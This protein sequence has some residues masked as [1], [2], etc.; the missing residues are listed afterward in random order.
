MGR[1]SASLS[2]TAPLTELA[3][4]LRTK[5]ARVGVIGLGYVGLPLAVEFGEAGFSVR[6]FDV[7]APRVTQVNQGRSYIPDVP[8][9]QL[10]ELVRRK[11]LTATR[12]YEELSACDAIIICVPTPLRK[13]REPDI[14]F[15]LGAAQ[16]IAKALRPGHLIVLEST[17]YPGTTEE[18][19]LPMLH[20]RGLRVGKDFS[21][22]F[23]PERIDPGNPRYTTH[24]IP[25]VVGG[26][27]PTCQKLAVTLY[28]QVVEKVVPVSSTKVAEMVKLLENTFRAV[29]IG[30]VNEIAL[31]CDKLGLDVWEVIEAAK[32]KPFGFMAFYPG[33]GIGGHCIPHD[34]MYLAWKARVHGFEARFIE[35]ADQMNRSMP[36]YVVD[37]VARTLNE[38][39]K[40]LNGSRILLLGLA[41]KQDVNDTR[42]SPAFE[43]AQA[44]RE[45]GGQVSYHDP[46]VPEAELSGVSA[47]SVPLSAAQL[48]RQDCVVILTNHSNVNYD[49]ILR[50]APLIVDTRNQYRRPRQAASHVT[51]L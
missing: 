50:H 37:K 9:K 30:L 43:I 45:R 34:P 19:L 11:R 15:I 4:R 39:R 51:K 40:A 26:M 41:Y 2:R 36:H 46:Y 20:A 29:N 8:G 12:S 5:Q 13:T 32:T 6:G 25:K 21:L 24:N 1:G 10:A 22:A 49:L 28:R 42:D 14:S 48:K 33:P 31:M 35:L 23:S 16:A 27:T 17:T 18:V 38:R 3:E 7:A 47:K 44:L